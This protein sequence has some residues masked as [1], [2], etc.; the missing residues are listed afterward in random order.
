VKV[1]VL[2]DS[3]VLCEDTM[4]LAE[5]KKEVERNCAE[6]DILCIEPSQWLPLDNTIP[7]YRFLATASLAYRMVDY[8]ILHAQFTFPLGFLLTFLKSFHRKPVIIHT[9]GD[10]V[11]VIPSEN[12][13]FQRTLLGR[14]VTK[15]SWQAAYRVLAVCEKAKQEIRT[16]G[17]AE[18]KISVLYNGVNENFFRKKT[19]ISDNRLI[20]IRESSDMIFLNV[21]HLKSV[22]NHA[23]L[24]IAFSHFVEKVKSKERVKLVLCGD[25]ALERSLRDLT[26]KLGIANSVAFLGRLP[27]VK[28]PE[29]YSVADAFILPSLHE[30]HPWSL[31]EAMSCELPIAA[32]SVGGIPESLTNGK[33]L[34]NP[35]KTHEILRAMEYLY[36]DSS[37]RERI[38]SQN[39]RIILER[40]SL[41]EHVSR[42]CSI[43]KELSDPM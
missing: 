11:F 29:L 41:R 3:P 2:T 31:L 12:I 5:L 13:G 26:E 17:I 19:R 30:A 10:D 24:L 14:F 25:G 37:R 34:F 23:R 22:K 36:E 39:R 28:M 33:L 8:D 27:H 15:V 43:Y 4:Y 42:L 35:W 6:M 20:D 1:A 9:H 38:G 40:F 7:I 16:A 32:S 21:G 18:S